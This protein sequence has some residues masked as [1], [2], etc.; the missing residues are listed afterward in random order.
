MWDGR[1]SVGRVL[2]LVEHLQFIPESRCRAI[3][4][5][6]D[7]RWIGWTQDTEVLAGMFDTIVAIAAGKKFN[8]ALRYQR[9]RVESA[10]AAPAEDK[11]FAPSIA[12]F[13]TASFMR[14]VD[15]Q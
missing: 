5:G 3:R 11:A 15:G 6:G 10:G 8:D 2:V 4:Y 1:V 13:N 7:P 9:P 12:D 14:E